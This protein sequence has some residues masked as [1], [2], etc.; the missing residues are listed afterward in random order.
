MGSMP[1]G[2][3]ESTYA[4]IYDLVAG[5]D[6][7]LTVIDA[8]SGLRP[9][10]R[11]L[12]SSSSSRSRSGSSR[13][14]MKRRGSNMFKVN[15]SELCR[16]AGVDKGG[17]ESDRAEEGVLREAAVAFLGEYGRSG[18]KEEEAD[19]QVHTV[20][21][22]VEEAHVRALSLVLSDEVDQG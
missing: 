5:S 13:R 22:H 14:G 17:E 21:E 1:P 8:V 11:S 2:C 15:A 20:H 16:L 6:N 7:T 10:F 4:D 12:S 9:L 18:G 19:N 3:A